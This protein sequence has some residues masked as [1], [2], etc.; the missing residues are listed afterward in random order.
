MSK[1]NNDGRHNSG[2]PNVLHD[3]DWIQVII[4]LI[5][6]FLMILFHFLH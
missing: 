2:T 1:G 5:V 4:G 3:P 6:I